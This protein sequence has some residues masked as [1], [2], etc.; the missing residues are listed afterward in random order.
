[1]RKPTFLKTRGENAGS[2]TLSYVHELVGGRVQMDS[3]VDG[4]ED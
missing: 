4:Q 1:M 3:C 2:F